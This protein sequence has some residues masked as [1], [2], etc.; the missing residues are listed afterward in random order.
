MVDYAYTGLSPEE[1]RVDIDKHI[2]E[3]ITALTTPL[4][5]VEQKKVI[6]KIATQAGYV[7]PWGTTELGPIDEELVRFTGSNYA[8]I[9]DKFQEK[10]LDWGWS[11]GFPII[12]PTTERVRDM[13]KGTS[14]APEEVLTE[15]LYPAHGIATVKMIAI[16]A[17]MAGARP[18]Y[19]PVILA[20]VQCM[21]DTGDRFILTAQTTSP[22][23]PFF[24]INGPIIKELG[25][26]CST[27][28]LGPGAQSRVN[29]AIGRAARLVMMNIGGAYLGVKDMDTIGAPDKFSLVAAENEDDCAALGWPTYHAS[30]GFSANDSVITMV[31]S[32]QHNH[33]IGMSTDSA[34]GLLLSFAAK[35]ESVGGPEWTSGPGGGGI[36]LMTGD[37]ARTCIRGGFKTKESIAEFIA[38][39]I[40]VSRD[41]FVKYFSSQATGFGQLDQMLAKYPAGQDIYPGRPE[42]ITVLRVGAM[43]GKDEIYG[44]GRGQTVKID[45]WR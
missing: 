43:E 32:T 8:Q 36:I 18:S 16:Q 5:K 33:I 23:T 26:N 20:A 30:I 21:I 25:I 42:R 17:V 11:D 27:G 29:I 28:T 7:A 38:K 39:N 14:H 3:L 22:S 31:S 45:D 41:A 4:E 10:F 6:E 44:G 37:D 9:Y 35:M 34:E 2:E 15:R 1:I 19:L 24:W 40:R 12:P 13:L